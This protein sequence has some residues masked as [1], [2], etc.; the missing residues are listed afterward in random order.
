MVEQ[1][2]RRQP[3][4]NLSS[5]QGPFSAAPFDGLEIEVHDYLRL[6]FDCVPTCPGAGTWRP[7]VCSISD[8]GFVFADDSSVDAPAL[9]PA[10]FFQGFLPLGI[11][12]STKLNNF[13]SLCTG[14]LLPW[15]GSRICPRFTRGRGNMHG[16]GI[17]DEAMPRRHGED[18]QR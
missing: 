10:G 18:G 2:R 17:A 11:C 13:P 9:L 16:H 1:L 12:C 7:C 15:T 4:P 5:D 8:A 3:L 14:H 6:L